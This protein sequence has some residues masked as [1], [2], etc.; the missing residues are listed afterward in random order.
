[1]GKLDGKVTGLT[2][3]GLTS[4][5]KILQHSLPLFEE[6]LG[7]EEAGEAGLLHEDMGRLDGLLPHHLRLQRPVERLPEPRQDPL[8]HHRVERLRVCKPIQTRPIK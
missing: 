5:E 2:W 1:M 3:H 8:L 7:G 6:A 4:G